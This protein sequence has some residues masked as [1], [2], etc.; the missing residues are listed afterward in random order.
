MGADR[1][2]FAR[3]AEPAVRAPGGARTPAT[4][5]T[6]SAHVAGW[7]VLVLAQSRP[8]WRDL[9]WGWRQ[10]ALGA[11]RARRDLP[12]LLFVRS[13]GSGHEGGFG[14]RPSR[15]R[16]GLFLVFDTAARA[17][18]FVADSPLLA[19][20]RRRSQECCVL[21]LRT[22][23]ARGSWGG[24]AI[25]PV[26]GLDG[27]APPADGTVVALTRASIRLSRAVSFWR[28]APP[29]Q[30]ALGH[31]EGCRLAVGLGEAPLLR[32]CTVSWW[33]SAGAMDAYARQGPHQQAIAASRRDDFFGE[34][35]FLR[36]QLL[37]C[38]GQ[39][40]GRS[41]GAPAGAPA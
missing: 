33:D 25:E 2:G 21:R 9:A 5:D 38:E 41:P 6:A 7:P 39:W 19:T 29:S 17:Q 35:M 4:H 22:T 8:G 34:S 11:W 23:R 28:H 14:L 27:G 3:E 30:A 32:Q 24:V 13:L 18:A 16:H 37:A 31:A 1:V 36:F 15:D 20:Y 40:L 10:V 26:A 12:G